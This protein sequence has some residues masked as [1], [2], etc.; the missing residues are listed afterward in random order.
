MW[1]QTADNGRELWKV[2]NWDKYSWLIHG[3]TSRHWG[4]LALH[5]EDTVDNV[6]TKRERLSRYLEIS[7]GSWVV[8]NQVHKTNIKKVK[9]SD[10]GCGAVDHASAFCDTDGMITDYPDLFLVTFYADCVPLLF[11]EP[12]SR[13]IGIAHAGWRGTAAQIGST[14][15]N[16]FR[17]AHQADLNDLEVAIGPAI[18]GCCYKISEQVAE[19]FSQQSLSYRSDG[20]YLDLCLANQLQLI[21]SGV[22]ANNIYPANECTYCN[23]SFFSFRREGKSAGRMAAFIYRS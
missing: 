13:T 21:A 9:P 4:N 22:N 12:K 1:Y 2:K 5:V 17:F 11:V 19:N 16:H 23:N 15:V 20:I 8:G 7:L 18:G 3:F 14:M 10:K 6:I